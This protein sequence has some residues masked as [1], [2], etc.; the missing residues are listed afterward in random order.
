MGSAKS[1]LNVT[2]T[3]KLAI[4]GFFKDA[5]YDD[6][7][8]DGDVDRGGP[9]DVFHEFAWRAASKD[10]AFASAIGQAAPTKEASLPS[11]AVYVD[12][13]LKSHVS[14]KGGPAAGGRSGQRATADSLLQWASGLLPDLQKSL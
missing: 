10:I 8:D 7:D 5:P 6:K 14:F 3:S 11:L 1:V 4:V 13:K 9:W 2:K 12:A